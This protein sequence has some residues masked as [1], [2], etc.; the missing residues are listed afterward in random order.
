MSLIDSWA[1]FWSR[2]AR[3]VFDRV[4]FPWTEQYVKAWCKV[5]QKY[6]NLVALPF[7]GRAFVKA[8]CP[9]MGYPDPPGRGGAPFPDM[10]CFGVKYWV[11][12]YVART[13]NGQPSPITL[14][15]LAVWGRVSD[16]GVRQD[17]TISTSFL[18]AYVT[19]FN[20]NGQP[21]TATASIGGVGV[22]ATYQYYTVRR[23]D[24][25]STTGACPTEYPDYDP[26]P[27]VDQRD[28]NPTLKIPIYNIN[29]NTITGYNYIPVKI[30]LNP[31]LSLGL[32]FEIGGDKYYFDFSGWNIGDPGNADGG[33]DRLPDGGG[34]G[35]GSGG[36][37]GGNTGTEFDPEV[38]DETPLEDEE[39]I[40]KP[41]IL[42]A[43]VVVIQLPDKGKR[44]VSL[45]PD[46]VDHFAGFFSWTI[47]QGG[48]YR[49]EEIPIR[50]RRY[51]F[52][53]PMGATGVKYYA[54]NGAILSV[55]VFTTKG[56]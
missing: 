30:N 33:G 1:D 44:L 39:D 46:N 4:G 47:N 40:Q 54:V 3:N 16:V 31:T 12:I 28:F 26:D 53:A 20:Q 29:N 42:W 15:E 8:T 5:V 34:G 49:M 17:P 35:G 36:G 27:P 21:F 24:G 38:L 10:R 23:D 43:K 13:F 18:Q 9:N 50:K 51:I 6:P 25:V 22:G 2:T 37:G 7:Y 19:G 11:R 48:I 52:R 45:N 41:G 14:P 55:S 56:V 32:D